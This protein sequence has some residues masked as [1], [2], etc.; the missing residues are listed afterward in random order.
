[1]RRFFLR[2]QKLHQHLNLVRLKRIAERW[3]ALASIPDLV[4]D[5]FFGQPLSHCAQV[6][7]ALCAS[8]IHP[9]AVLASTLVKHRRPIFLLAA[10][11]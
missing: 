11:R 4:L 2:M 10:L 1:M 8:R 9:M 7:R 3:H 6:R 5:L